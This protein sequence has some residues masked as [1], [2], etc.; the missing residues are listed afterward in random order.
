MYKTIS[1]VL[2]IKS[3]ICFIEHGMEWWGGGRGYSSG[4]MLRHP[5]F[6]CSIE[7]SLFGGMGRGVEKGVEAEKERGQRRWRER[8]RREEREEKREKRRERERRERRG[9]PIRNM[10][11]E[12]GRGRGK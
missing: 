2:F 8:E 7:Q 1:N 4:L 6:L 12:R 3:M 10:W 9:R 5:F 11:R